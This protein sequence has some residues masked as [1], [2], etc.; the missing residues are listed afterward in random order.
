MYAEMKV[1]G[2]YRTHDDSN[3]ALSSEFCRARSTAAIGSLY[4]SDKRSIRLPGSKLELRKVFVNRGADCLE[5]HDYG[6][7]IPPLKRA[8]ELNPELIGARGQ[9]TKP[10]D[11]PH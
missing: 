10:D 5:N 1:I 8:L 11:L 2:L 3:W 4:L 6:S 7:A 9:T